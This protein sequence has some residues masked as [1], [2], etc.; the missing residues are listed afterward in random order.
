[1]SPAPAAQSPLGPLIKM[2]GAKVVNDALGAYAV[3]N[4]CLA[5][6]GKA[7]YVEEEDEAQHPWAS[8]S[9]KEQKVWKERARAA[10]IGFRTHVLG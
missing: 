9:P 8:L 2:L 5:A 6:M 1:M 4:D 3:N 7:M 10:I